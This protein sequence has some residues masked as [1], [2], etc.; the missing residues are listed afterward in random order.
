VS[1]LA[2]RIREPDAGAPQL[3][4]DYGQEVTQESYREI[5]RLALWAKARGPLFYLIGGWAAWR[6]HRGYGS[7]DIDVIFPN[8]QILD[9]FLNEYCRVNEYERT[10]G[11]LAPAYRKPVQ[12]PTGT[13]Y[14]EIDAAQLDKGPPFHENAEI[15]IP[16]RLLERYNQ[17]WRVGSQDVL[18]PTPELLL[19]QKVK[20]YRDRS[21]DLEHTAADVRRLAI[22]RSKVA[23]DAYD[24]QGIAPH[25][26]HWELVAH[27]ADERGCRQLI[28]ETLL[29]LNV[30]AKL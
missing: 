23:K 1:R 26:D 2:E 4:V 28:A 13:Q 20:A 16:Y 27:I 12:T 19:L 7:R 8:Q 5:E 29:N 3:A 9:A 24:I 10:G 15:D 6:Y 30:S 21:W 18:M 11:L 17:V 22:L 25:I 14:I